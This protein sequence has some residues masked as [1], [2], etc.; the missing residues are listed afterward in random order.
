MNESKNQEIKTDEVPAL[1][2]E[3]EAALN[4]AL[5][6]FE[7]VEE[8]ESQ[9]QSADDGSAAMVGMFYAGAFQILSAR[10]GEH[11]ALDQAEV[12]A[13]A[14]PTVAVVK[15]Y[16]PNA[17]AGPEAALIGAAAMIV[18]PRLMFKDEKEVKDNQ[19]TTEQQPSKT[20]EQQPQEPSNHGGFD[21]NG[22]SDGN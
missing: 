17:K 7:P 6:E 9:K 20:T 19:K 3:T 14:V 16:M 11:W 22:G 18:L 4:S 1:D 8:N 12:E 2:P 15:K 10:L 5:A 21:V 13:L